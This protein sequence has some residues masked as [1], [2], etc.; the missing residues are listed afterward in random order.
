MWS[1]GWYQIFTSTEKVWFWATYFFYFKSIL[2]KFK[3]LSTKYLYL[4]IALK[5]K[6]KNK[7]KSSFPKSVNNVCLARGLG[8]IAFGFVWGKMTLYLCITIHY[9]NLKGAKKDLINNLNEF[10]NFYQK[11]LTKIRVKK[12]LEQLSRTRCFTRFK[13]RALFSVAT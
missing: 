8:A 10:A 3:F 1:I 12:I 5:Y 11:L 7:N 6:I 13:I 2:K 9:F 4:V